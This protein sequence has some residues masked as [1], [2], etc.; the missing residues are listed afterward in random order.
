MTKGQTQPGET[1]KETSRSVRP[2]QDNKWPNSML[3]RW[4]WWCLF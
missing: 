2:E 4:W 1:I 3:A